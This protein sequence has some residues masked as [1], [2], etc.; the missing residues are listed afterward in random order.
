[1]IEAARGYCNLDIKRTEDKKEGP[2]I[3]S[4]TKGNPK[5]FLEIDFS[6]KQGGCKSAGTYSPDFDECLSKFTSILDD[7]RFFPLIF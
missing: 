4:N 5:F 2:C 1:L 7:C 3:S 6:E